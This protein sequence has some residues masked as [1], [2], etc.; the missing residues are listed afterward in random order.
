MLRSPWNIAHISLHVGRPNRCYIETRVRFPNWNM[1][2]GSQSYYVH[3]YLQFSATAKIAGRTVFVRLEYNIH[4]STV[5]CQNGTKHFYIKRIIYVYLDVIRLDEF[6]MLR[7]FVLF[8][9]TFERVHL[10]SR[11]SVRT[12]CDM[13]L[14]IM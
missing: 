10:L 3:I 11:K 2:G 4:Q 6:T 5:T 7:I 9:S 8:L 14:I 13:K 12:R 1:S